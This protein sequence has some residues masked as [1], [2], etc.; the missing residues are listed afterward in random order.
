MAF[1]LPSPIT[2]IMRSV[3]ALLFVISMPACIV[4]PPLGGMFLIVG[5]GLFA[6]GKLLS[7]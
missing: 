3:G 5:I 4:L 7:Q 2:K 6:G 1:K